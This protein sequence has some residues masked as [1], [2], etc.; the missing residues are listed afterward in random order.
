MSLTALQ[1]DSAHI[2]YLP[3]F[4]RLR[5]MKIYLS[6]TEKKINICSEQQLFYIAMSFSYGL[7]Y[8]NANNYPKL[9]DVS[10]GK[11]TSLSSRRLRC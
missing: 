1:Y 3:C 5:Y 6:R 11:I 7:V 8:V 2:Y 9:P 4:Y 10:S